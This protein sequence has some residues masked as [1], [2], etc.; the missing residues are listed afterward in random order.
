MPPGSGAT[1]HGSRLS[2]ESVIRWLAAAIAALIA[3]AGLSMLA[4]HVLAP[5]R[6]G[7][8]VFSQ[9][10]EPYLLLAL[11]V[12]A[13]FFVLV[14]RRRVAT[15]LVIALVVAAALR[16]GPLLIS[17]PAATPAGA[18]RLHLMTWNLAGG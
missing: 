4:V 7:P 10:F 9:I 3:L 11:I 18:Q 2:A 16:Y 15:I 12:G 14:A 1:A 8:L 5:Q 13:L 17:F 6:A